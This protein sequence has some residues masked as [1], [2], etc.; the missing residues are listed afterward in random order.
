MIDWF[1]YANAGGGT[2]ARDALIKLIVA[3]DPNSI[4]ST[5]YTNVDANSDVVEQYRD[6]GQSSWSLIN[7][8]GRAGTGGLRWGA[9][10]YENRRLVYKQ[11]EALDSNG[12][13]LAENKHSVISRSLYDAGE[14][15]FDRAGRELQVWE[16]RPDRL[17]RTTGLSRA[18]QFVEQVSFS[19][20]V[21][22][23]IRS[24]DAN[25]LRGVVIV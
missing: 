2:I 19:A 16:I 17:I 25:P 8:V 7:E 1:N 12:D 3:A 22:L 15:F 13:E 5:D 10:V 18:P 9:G 24:T 21:G 23:E 6:G 14:R 11:V 4:L 20:P